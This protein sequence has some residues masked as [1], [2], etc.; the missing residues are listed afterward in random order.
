MYT[1]KIG[2]L[3]EIKTLCKL[4]LPFL[5]GKRR[6]A[7]IVLEFI[8]LTPGRHITRNAKGQNSGKSKYTQRHF[9]LIDE[10]QF[11]NKRYAKGE[12][13]TLQRETERLAPAMH[14]QDEETIRA[15]W[16]HAETSRNVSSA[17]N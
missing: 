5:S 12:W 8:S 13:A 1:I 16:Q 6:Q 15:A 17:V 9:D 2:T 11:L 14:K 10:I 3:S 4:I 7:E